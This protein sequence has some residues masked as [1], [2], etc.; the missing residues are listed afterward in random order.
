MGQSRKQLDPVFP[1]YCSQSA[2][3]L[4]VEKLLELWPNA[5]CER[6]THSLMEH[7]VTGEVGMTDLQVVDYTFK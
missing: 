3:G 2:G 7:V 6:K 4:T 1:E 5:P